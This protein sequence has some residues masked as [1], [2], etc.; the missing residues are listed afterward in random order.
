[1]FGFEFFLGAMIFSALAAQAVTAGLA[2]ANQPD[3]PD[4][5]QFLKPPKPP[6]GEADL[7]R[8]Q[9][10]DQRQAQRRRSALA[11]QPEGPSNPFTLQ[12]TP[13]SNLETGRPRR[14]VLGR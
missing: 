1:M 5:S 14:S 2:L 6:V 9:E 12:P 3:P 8:Q 7:Q 10:A 4:Y 11:T 13:P